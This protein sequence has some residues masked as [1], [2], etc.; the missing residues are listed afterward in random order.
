MEFLNPYKTFSKM[1]Y[2][3][4]FNYL[5]CLF[6]EI[7]IFMVGQTGLFDN[8]IAYL[9]AILERPWNVLWLSIHKKKDKNRLNK[10]ND[11]NIIRFAHLP[12]QRHFSSSFEFL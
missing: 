9:L 8:D 11:M 6:E 2:I 5:C 10:Q 1:T 3:T 4:K 12:L 7:N